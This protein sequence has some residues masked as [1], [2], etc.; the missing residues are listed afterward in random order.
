MKVG[1]CSAVLCHLVLCSEVLL[2]FFPP[3][4]HRKHAGGVLAAEV[5]GKVSTSHLNYL[6]MSFIHGK[7]LHF[8]HI[9]S[10]ISVVFNFLMNVT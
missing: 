5:G 1:K 10:N 2:V 4:N 3:L 8:E 6:K 9:I 7:K